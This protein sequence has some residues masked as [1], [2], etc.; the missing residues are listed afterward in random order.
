[1]IDRHRCDTKHTKGYPDNDG[2]PNKAEI[3]PEVANG[4]ELIHNQVDLLGEEPQYH[5]RHGSTFGH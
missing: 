4:I 1:M 5:L 3:N 2:R